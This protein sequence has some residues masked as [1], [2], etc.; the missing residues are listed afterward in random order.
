MPTKKV[1]CLRIY[2]FKSNYDRKTKKSEYY[3]SIT[4]MVNSNKFSDNE[5]FAKYFVQKSRIIFVWRSDQ[6]RALP[7]DKPNDNLHNL[8]P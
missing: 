3:K 5:A 8:I 2:N 1:L 6:G 4:R 7:A